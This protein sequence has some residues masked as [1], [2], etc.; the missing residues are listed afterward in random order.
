MFIYTKLIIG[1]TP[2]TDDIIVIEDTGLPAGAD[3]LPLAKSS[4]TTADLL[5]K[6]NLCPEDIRV[7]ETKTIGQGKNPLWSKLRK[8]RLTA[9]NFYRVYTRI[10]SLKKNPILDCSNLV[11]SFLEPTPLDHLPQIQRGRD[12]EASAVDKLVS[13]LGGNGHSGIGIRDCGLFID[14]ATQYLGASPDGIVSC[15]CCS[16]SLAEI[17]CPS[18]ELKDLPYF[19][20]TMKLKTRHAYYGQIQGQMMVTGIKSTWFFV[21]YPNSDCHLELIKLNKDFCKNMR[22][23]LIHFY[24]LHMAPKLVLGAK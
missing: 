19:D 22:Q 4:L 7:L 15:D 23:N 9:S 18:T 20:E 17:K 3:V 1:R 11:R 2:E 10:E 21:F 13:M 6:L 14:H 12:L 16:P 8:G 24:E 5:K